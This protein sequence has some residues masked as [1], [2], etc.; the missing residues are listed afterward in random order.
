MARCLPLSGL[1]RAQLP[2]LIFNNWTKQRGQSYFVSKEHGR[3][4]FRKRMR[5]GYSESDKP[6]GFKHSLLRTV[7]PELIKF[8]V[9]A[10]RHDQL[11][12]F[13]LRANQGLSSTARR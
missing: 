12:S 2:T 7:V 5:L 10:T 6:D 3:F 8:S 1:L 9:R 11:V 13:D 4:T